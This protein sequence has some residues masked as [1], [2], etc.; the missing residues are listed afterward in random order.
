MGGNELEYKGYTTK[1]SYSAEDQILHGKIEDI[2][3][4][5]DFQS[6]SAKDIVNEFHNAV[7]DYFS[8]CKEVGKE[9]DKV[10][11]INDFSY[12]LSIGDVKNDNSRVDRRNKN[13]QECG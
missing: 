10:I 11:N 5:V 2:N 4:L 3:D 8:F 13:S 6:D 7:D 12:Y 1:I 9:P